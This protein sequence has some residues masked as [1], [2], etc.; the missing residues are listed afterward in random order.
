M[1]ITEHILKINVDNMDFVSNFE[2]KENILKLIDNKIKE[3][4]DQTK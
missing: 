1:R 4:E 2:D 3:I